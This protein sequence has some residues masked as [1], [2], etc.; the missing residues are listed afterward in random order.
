MIGF[1]V[2]KPAESD[3]MIRQNLAMKISLPPAI[4]LA[5]VVAGIFPAYADSDPNHIA[6]REAIGKTYY[7]VKEQFV[8][9]NKE[10]ES[11]ELVVA[12]IEKD[13]GVKRG[14]SETLGN[15]KNLLAELEKANATRKA[16][17]DQIRLDLSQ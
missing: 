5:F 3:A 16:T 6:K 14:L 1:R 12:A 17:L 15:L 11:L 2:W 13:P 8:S 10:I 4:A 7:V 9:T